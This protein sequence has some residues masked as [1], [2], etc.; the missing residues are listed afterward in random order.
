[1]KKKGLTQV[2]LKISV[3]LRYLNQDK[4]VRGKE[5]LKMYSKL[6][7]AT[8]YRHAKKPLGDKTVDKRKHIHGRTR[9]ISPRDKRLILR[10][11]HMLREQ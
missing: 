6:S 3:H 4:D 10:K 1:M 8:I 9:K 7:K 2:P 5:L 11:I